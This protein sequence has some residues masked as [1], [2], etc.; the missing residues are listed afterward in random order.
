MLRRNTAVSGPLS[1]G[2]PGRPAAGRPRRARWGVVAVA[3]AAAAALAVSLATAG[4]A[5]ARTQSAGSVAQLSA[6]AAVGADVTYSTTLNYLIRFYPRYL[7]AWLESTAPQN[8]FLAPTSALDGLLTS[9]ARTINA[10]N[11]DTVY[12][13]VLNMNVSQGPEI[14]T[15]PQSTSTTSLLS[16]DVWGSVFDT[17]IKTDQPGTYAL[18]LAGWR[19]VLP[20]GVKRVTVPVSQFEFTIRADR[21]SRS[22]SGYANTIAAGKAFIAGLRL[23]SLADYK[24]NPD[25]GR[26]LPTPQRLI[27]ASSKVQ[28]DDSLANTPTR[29]LSDLQVAMHSANTRP[30]TVSDRALSAAFDVVFAAAQRGVSN[31]NYGLMAQVNQAAAEVDSMIVDRYRS[32]L[33]AGTNWIS[34]DNL[35]DWG[36]AYLDRDAT[37]AYIFLGNSAAT[38]RYWDA[39][40]DHNG[41]PLDTGIYP[42]YTMTF[43]KDQIPDAKRF[44]SLTAYVGAALHVTPGPPNNGNRNVASYTPGLR[45]NKDGSITIFIGPTPPKILALRPNWVFVPPDTPFSLVLR[46]YGAQGNTAPGV[47]YSPPQIKALGIL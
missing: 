14:L 12:A 47:T 27:T 8:R 6:P 40:T 11:V 7:T 30:L 32:H 2:S 16:L 13:S 44:W 19:G 33:V 3:G 5:G 1:S 20:A 23:A 43:T 9:D 26:P 15:V 29:F 39:F 4:G 25:S 36:T 37:T 35:A 17:G 42:L 45:T 28:A 10:F 41:H 31:G 22:G 18:A 24:A 21:Y 38:S 34:F 46:T